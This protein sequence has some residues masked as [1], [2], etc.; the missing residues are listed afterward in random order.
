MGESNGVTATFFAG[1]RT[2]WFR[3]DFRLPFGLWPPPVIATS[4]TPKLPD[5][6]TSPW[7][8]RHGTHF[9]GQRI[10]LVVG[11]SLSLRPP[12][13]CLGKLTRV[14]PGA[15]L[16]VIVWPQVAVGMVNIS[17]WTG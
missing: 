1:S 7:F 2:L 17:S 9:E 14:C 5:D 3:P 8:R 12:N 11:S 16:W 13:M 10:P 4:R 15:S 6:G